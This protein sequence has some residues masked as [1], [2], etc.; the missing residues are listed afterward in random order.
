MRNH[1]HSR[2]LLSSK[3]TNEVRSQVNLKSSTMKDSYRLLNPSMTTSKKPSEA[4]S[5][6]D[7]N[8]KLAQENVQLKTKVCKVQ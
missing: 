4:K 3:L 5:L 1:P 8:K 7:E 6:L 2:N